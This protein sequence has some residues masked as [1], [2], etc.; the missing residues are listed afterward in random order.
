MHRQ[1]A[2]HDEETTKEKKNSHLDLLSFLEL[3]VSP[4]RDLRC[5]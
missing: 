1:L 2:R 3:S 5:P 4:N